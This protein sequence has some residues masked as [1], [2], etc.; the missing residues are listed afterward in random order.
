VVVIPLLRFSVSFG[1]VDRCVHFIVRVSFL[2]RSIS[3]LVFEDLGM[4]LLETRDCLQ[5]SAER[6]TERQI[7]T[8]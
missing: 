8:S 5:S 6:A 4:I 7:G 3:L 1:L 2:G